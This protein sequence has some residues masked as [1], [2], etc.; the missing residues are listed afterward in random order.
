MKRLLSLLAV[1]VLLT[2]CGGGGGGDSSS[3]GGGGAVSPE[4]I[5]TYQGT[6]I[7]VATGSAGTVSQSLPMTVVIANDGR[8][9][10]AFNGVVSSAT[11]SGGSP[12]FISGNSFSDSATLTCQDPQLGSCNVNATMN[13]NIANNAISGTG[14]Y[15]YNCTAGSFTANISY[16]ATKSVAAQ[17][18]SALS[19]QQIG[20]S[21][22]SEVFGKSILELK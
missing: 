10:V 12:I 9:S 19:N 16:T 21:K 7:I 15:I 17:S 2:G 14:K 20:T 8:V 1:L 4:N 3:G 13:G 6:A 11:C 5:G 18:I 22:M